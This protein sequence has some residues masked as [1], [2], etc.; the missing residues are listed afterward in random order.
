MAKGGAVCAN[1]AHEGN[2][3][4]RVIPH[5]GLNQMQGDDLARFEEATDGSAV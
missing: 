5:R 2:R 3:G 1:P 4:L